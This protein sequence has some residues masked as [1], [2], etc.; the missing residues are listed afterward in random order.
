MTVASSIW[1][2]SGDLASL[3]SFFDDLGA[4]A[5]PWNGA[6][7]WASTEGDFSLTATCTALGRVT[8]QVDLRGEEGTEE[9]WRVV[10]GLESE[11][12]QLA[13]IAAEAT[14]VAD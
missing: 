5:Q 14:T 8:F 7:A 12:G 3:V 10:A 9:A 11:L 1:L 6:R 13:R 4:Q 2:R